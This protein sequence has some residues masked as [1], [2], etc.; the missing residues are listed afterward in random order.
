MNRQSNLT[1]SI[2]KEAIVRIAFDLDGIGKH[3][4]NS[5]NKTLNHLIETFARYGRFNI[6]L[7]VESDEISHHL[8][9]QTGTA[10]GLAIDSAIGNRN[11]LKQIA[12][13]SVPTDGAVADIAVD[14]N[15]GYGRCDFQQCSNFLESTIYH[16]GVELSCYFHLLEKIAYNAQINLHV[17]MLNSRDNHHAVEVLYKTA[18]LSIHEA[19]RKVESPI[20]RL[21][22]KISIPE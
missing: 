7:S 3:S 16:D 14:L 15:A 1:W 8:F 22:K 21:A 4:V 18:A 17:M 19:S 13:A 9:E 12:R 6:E 5:G 10:I 2:G 20:I 11:E